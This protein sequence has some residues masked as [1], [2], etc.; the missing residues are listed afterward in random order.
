[1][2]DMPS[3]CPRQPTCPLRAHHASVKLTAGSEPAAAGGN[4]I[5]EPR[6]NS[7]LGR[8]LVSLG[9]IA[10]SLVV[11]ALALAV[12]WI[13]LPRL[14]LRLFGLASHVRDWFVLL[15]W[16]PSYDAAVRFFFD[17]RQIVYLGFVVASRILVGLGAML[18]ARRFPRHS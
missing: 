12:V 9:H 8:L 4:A 6:V 17:E 11:G 15:N 18:I 13:Y 5:G 14:A 16:P 1:M 7:L 2:Q 10:V 3:V